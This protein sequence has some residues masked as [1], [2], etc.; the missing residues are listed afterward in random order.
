MRMERVIQSY[1]PRANVRRRRYRGRMLL[2]AVLGIV[3]GYVWFVIVRGL[4]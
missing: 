2:G 1:R 4:W 3:G